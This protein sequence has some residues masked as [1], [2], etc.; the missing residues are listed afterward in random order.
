ML[1]FCSITQS[2]RPVHQYQLEWA[3]DRKTE[4]VPPPSLWL[5]CSHLPTCL[6]LSTTFSFSLCPLFSRFAQSTVSFPLLF[7][8]LHFVHISVLSVSEVH[9]SYNHHHHHHK[10]SPQ[11]L[12]TAAVVNVVVVAVRVAVGSLHQTCPSVKHTHTH[13]NALKQQAPRLIHRQH[14]RQ[15]AKSPA[16]CHL[17][18]ATFYFV[19]FFLLWL[20]SNT[21]SWVVQHTH[22]LVS[23]PNV[24]KTCWVI[25]FA[26]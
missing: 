8:S 11:Y 1:L 6:L 2:L 24:L 19:V 12:S 5:K 9:C 25:C 21:L 22:T 14:T 7:C 18:G 26:F 16:G 23:L 3:R 4:Q 20:S 15:V 17:Q 10:V 13:T